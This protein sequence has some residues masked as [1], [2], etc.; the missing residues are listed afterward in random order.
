MKQQRKQKGRSEKARHTKNVQLAVLK[1]ASV[2]LIAP[3]SEHISANF[4]HGCRVCLYH[5]SLS[6]TYHSLHFTFTFHLFHHFTAQ[7]T[8]KKLESCRLMECS[9]I[10]CF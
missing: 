5:I 6:L 2:S 3:S 9:F 1:D 10:C 8:D 4:K 7:L